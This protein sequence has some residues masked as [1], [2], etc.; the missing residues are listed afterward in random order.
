MSTTD[1]NSDGYTFLVVNEC[2]I[3]LE[4][5]SS[6][7]TITLKCCKTKIHQE[8][9]FN[10]INKPGADINCPNCRTPIS[11]DLV[12]KAQVN[13]SKYPNCIFTTKFCTLLYCTCLIGLCVGLFSIPK[14][15]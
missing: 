4:N 2:C 6:K 5:I 14:D 12:K 9:I 13:T 7:P 8:C 10:W 1:Y 3:C 15:S 11:S